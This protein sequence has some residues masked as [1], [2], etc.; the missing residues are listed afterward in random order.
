MILTVSLADVSI[1]VT[2]VVG[3]LGLLLQF[4]SYR[5][6]SRP[7]RPAAEDSVVPPRPKTRTKP[8]LASNEDARVNV[9]LPK[10]S[11]RKNSDSA[12]G[13]SE[14]AT[15]NLQWKAFFV[16]FPLLALAGTAT[17]AIVGL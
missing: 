15:W 1:I 3:V 16:G 8:R 7:R 4:A 12:Q 5:R 2:I 13:R 10:R 11:I 17:V 9:D 6:D 14:S